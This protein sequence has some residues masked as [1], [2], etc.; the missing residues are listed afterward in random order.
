MSID[1]DG[2]GQVEVE[3]LRRLEQSDLRLN[4]ASRS[5]SA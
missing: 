4:S 2:F 5:F 3:K 1:D